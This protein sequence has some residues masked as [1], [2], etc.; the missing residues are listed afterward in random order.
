MLFVAVSCQAEQSLIGVT[1][2]KGNL[3]VTVQNPWE[4]VDTT[5]S[6]D[7]E[8]NALSVTERTKKLVDA[9]ILA[10]V[11]G[12]DEISLF[13][14]PSK[15]NAIRLRNIGI[16]DGNSITHQIYLGTL[17]RGDDC[18]LSYAGQL[19]WV[20]G[21]QQS[22]YDQ[23]T[24]TSGGTYVPKPGDTVTGN[25]SDETAVI[26]DVLLSSGA[27]ADGDAAGTLTY[28]S[29]SGV[30]TNSET[31]KI[32]NYLDVTQS[33]VLTHAASDLIDFELSDTVTITEGTWG[34]TWAKKS[35]A[36]N[37]NAE[38]EIDVK[39]ADYLVVL[40]SVCEVDGKLLIKGY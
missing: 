1:D 6:A 30:F 40:T 36:D 28:R 33:N 15:W 34:A 3:T 12:D 31:V 37:T 32:V 29:A 9:A 27:W 26:V 38:V 7:N 20:I 5:T 10:G 18:E 11:G 25:S 19:V 14:I 16:T 21:T 8:P 22:I 35:P 24:F 17:G 23:I 4:I 13:A 2:I 39:G